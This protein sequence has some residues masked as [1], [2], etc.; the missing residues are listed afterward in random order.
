MRRTIFEA[1]HE[2]YR[3]VVRE[4]VNRHLATQ[5]DRHRQEHSI[6]RQTWRRAGEFGLLGFFVPEQY[7]GGGA[8]D[9]R[10]NAV[11]GEELSRLS[12]GYASAFGINTDIVA[13]YLLELTTEQQKQRWLPPFGL[14]ELI[15]SIAIT[16]PG[17]GSDVLGIRTTARRDGSGWILNGAK[18]F[19]TNG[20]SADLII[21]A[22]KSEQGKPSRSISLF[23]VE[24]AVSPIGRGPSLEKVGQTE[25]ETSELFFD[26]V[27][28]QDANLLGE[29]GS[30]FG[31]M[32]ERLAQE[33]LSCAVAS[34]GHARAALDETIEYVR[35]R[36]AFGQS[37]GAFQ[38]TR[39]RL[40]ECH[41]ML[42][43][44]TAWIDRCI[45]AH[46]QGELTPVDAAKAKLAAT[47]VQNK[48]IDHCL[49]LHG[50]YGYMQEYRIA[51]AWQDARVTRIF[52][53]TS[54]VMREIIGRSL[55][56]SAQPS[57][58]GVRDAS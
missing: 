47:E 31:Y 56:L 55:S 25:V 33:R 39:F 30:G 11:Q 15:A 35:H 18:T 29:P 10:F 16:E 26:D 42:D 49:Q 3:Q 50:G 53:G 40:A 41:T 1:E 7:G 27:Y 17:A 22:A 34:L 19:I 12:Y 54:E 43:V 32:V 14:G 45:E 37:I 13:P 36:S 51:R 8:G 9:F 21:V 38:A 24:T 52:G 20:S 44:A 46:V 6:D 57:R 23:V 2:A 4:F 58:K 28:V 48:V 5:I